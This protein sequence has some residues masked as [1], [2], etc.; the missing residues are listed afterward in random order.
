MRSS[1][2]SPSNILCGA[3]LV[4]G[5]SK[6]I[7][8][9]SHSF[10]AAYAN[11]GLLI[12]PASKTVS[13]LTGVFESLSLTP[14]PLRQTNFPV[15]MTAIESPGTLASSISFGIS[16]SNS[17]TAACQRS[18]SFASAATDRLCPCPSE[19]SERPSAARLLS[20]RNSLRRIQSSSAASLDCDALRQI[21]RF[22]DV[23]TAHDGD[24]VG[25]QLQRD[26]CKEREQRLNRR[27]HVNHF[28]GFFHDGFVPLGGYGND[29]PFARFDHLQIA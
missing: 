15:S 21:A 5:V 8:P 22:V 9:F 27:R 6:P 25:E 7:T 18:V 12:D 3:Y 26:D 2:G 23:T 11:T 28:V 14:N 4:R 16:F 20:Q 24:V 17:T 13:L 29:W 1:R 10:I 19:R